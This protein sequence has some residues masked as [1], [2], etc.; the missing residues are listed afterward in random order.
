MGQMRLRTRLALAVA[1][2]REPTSATVEWLAAN[3]RTRALSRVVADDVLPWRVRQD[4]ARALGECS[5][6]AGTAPLAEIVKKSREFELVE[7]A[8]LALAKRGQ[9][10]A[11]AGCLRLIDALIVG[12]GPTEGD[13]QN[14]E[15]IAEHGVAKVLDLLGIAA[16][17]TLLDPSILPA[18]VLSAWPDD[19]R[20]VALL[21]IGVTA[22][23]AVMAALSSPVPQTAACAAR[24]AARVAGNG[25][26]AGLVDALGHQSA[27][28]RK[29]AISSLPYLRAEPLRPYLAGLMRDPSEDVREQAARAVVDLEAREAVPLLVDLL[30]DRSGRTRALAVDALLQLD[31]PELRPHITLLIADRDERV[32]KLAVAAA[33][34]LRAR[35]AVPAL[36][37]LAAGPGF[38]PEWIDAIKALGDIGD[39]SAVP[40][41]GGMLSDPTGRSHLAALALA[42][43]GPAGEQA[44]LEAAHSGDAA[45]SRAAV[46]GLLRVDTSAA[47]DGI[48]AAAAADPDVRIGDW[49]GLTDPIRLE[50]LNDSRGHVRAAAARACGYDDAP[51]V[52]ALLRELARSDPDSRARAWALYS[53]PGLDPEAVSLR[54]VGLEDPNPIMRQWSAVSLGIHDPPGALEALRTRLERE[55]DP[56][57]KDEIR[58]YLPRMSRLVTR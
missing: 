21:R 55:T 40:L 7:E 11:V 43:I 30:S 26:V 14:L 23:T 52:A 4:A 3:G 9:M 33:G 12:Y 58:K 57:V 20:V 53:L 28:V 22:T 51:A 15:T 25:A 44:L 37:V 19:A 5:A 32:Q 56:G 41:L 47:L 2:P 49:V 50:L 13:Q 29:D 34:R 6:P 39:P 18:G 46:G 31:V 10:Q 36:L 38:H 48:L 16:V 8:T 54:L 24:V 1:G 35:E 42:E 27:D 17:E 45:R